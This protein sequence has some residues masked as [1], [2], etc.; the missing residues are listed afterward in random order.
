MGR[1]DEIAF[2]DGRR[3]R[4]TR[5]AGGMNHPAEP[6]EAISPRQTFEG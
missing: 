5:A 1:V 6:S 4:E 2:R 3:V